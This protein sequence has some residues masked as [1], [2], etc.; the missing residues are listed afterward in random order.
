M[1]FAYFMLK[2]ILHFFSSAKID[3][4][5]NSKLLY[6]ESYFETYILR[7]IINKNETET[8]PRSLGKRMMSNSNNE[9]NKEDK[10]VHLP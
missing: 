2:V 7:C 3:H 5:C 10:I 1:W 8:N 9:C 6:L 4:C